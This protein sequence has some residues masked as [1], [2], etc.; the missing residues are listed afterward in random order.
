MGVDDV[1]RN[2]A[3]GD[4]PKVIG[5]RCSA[6]TRI[7]LTSS[8]TAQAYER[9][10]VEG[11]WRWNQSLDARRR[12][13]HNPCDTL[14]VM[15]RDELGDGAAGVV[16]HDQDVAQAR[17]SRNAAMPGGVRSARGTG[18]SCD[19]RGSS[20]VRGGWGESAFPP[21]DCHPVTS[22]TTWPSGS[23]KSAKVTPPGTCVGGWTALPPNRSIWSSAACA[24]STPT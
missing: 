22:P 6:R 5:G 19:P 10:P 20:G 8:R 9:R 4:Q 13:R 1:E 15:D 2:R 23:A 17:A 12:S 3:F 18:A 7:S 11:E 16:G 24:S 21:R 14:R